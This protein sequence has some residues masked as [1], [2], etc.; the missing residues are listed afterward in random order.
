MFSDQAHALQCR[1]RSLPELQEVAVGGMHGSK[2]GATKPFE[3][4]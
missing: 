2:P 1:W 4:L 3:K